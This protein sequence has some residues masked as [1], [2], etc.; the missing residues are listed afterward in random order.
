MA[1]RVRNIIIHIFVASGWL[2]LMTGCEGTMYQSLCVN[3]SASSS[4]LAS[5]AQQF[6]QEA[7]AAFLF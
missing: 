5:F 7:L 3:L 4:D 6:A 1:K 2:M